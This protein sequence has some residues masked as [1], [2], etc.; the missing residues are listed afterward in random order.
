MHNSFFKLS[1]YLQGNL[2]K[3]QFKSGYAFAV[4]QVD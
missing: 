3:D 4:G 1:F 2:F